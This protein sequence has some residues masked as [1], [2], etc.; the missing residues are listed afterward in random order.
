MPGV[1]QG[2]RAFVTGGNRG[3]GLAVVAEL[4]SR[5]A[6]VTFT[7]RSQSGIEEAMGLLPAG[8]AA[9]G[10]IC[11]VTDQACMAAAMIEPFDILINNAGL[12]GPIAR[13]A[14][15]DPAAWADNHR[16]NVLSAFNAIRLALPGLIDRKG[17]VV[18]LSSGAATHAMEG[19]SAYCAGKAA[20]AMITACVHLEYGGLGVRAFG[21]LP[22]LV[23]TGMQASIRDSGINSISRLRRENLRPAVEPGLAIAWLCT[24]D[25]NDLIGH[26]IDIR[27]DE[28][29]RRCG[30]EALQ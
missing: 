15:V 11:N 21:F 20:L 6:N 4:A 22:G 26:E 2:R 9:R 18:N 30:L 16:T 17:T 3:I 24:P 25:A 29:R 7:S 14:D 5:G 27:D 12:I 8:L 13:I 19:W 23:D 28:I 1:L 10:I